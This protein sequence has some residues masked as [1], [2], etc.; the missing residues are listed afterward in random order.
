LA[1]GS[2]LAGAPGIQPIRKPRKR[3]TK[4]TQTAVLLLLLL[5]IWT[6]SGVV[7]LYIVKIIAN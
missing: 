2:E 4:T 6:F 3:T 5:F 7:Y 1:I